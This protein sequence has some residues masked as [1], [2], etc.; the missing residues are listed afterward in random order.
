MAPGAALTRRGWTLAGAASGLIVAGRLLGAAELSVLGVITVSLL[1]AA[2]LWVR[3]RKR[4]V[5]VERSVHPHR[6]HVGGDARVDIEV[7]DPG[8]ADSPQ[9]MLTDVFDGGRRAAR[10][11]VP[12]L[13]RGQRARAAYR[14]PTNRR[15]RY[16]LGPISLTVTDPFGLARRSWPAGAADEVTICPRVHELRPPPGAPGRL[17]SASPFAVRFHAP[18]VDGEEFLTLREYEVG[19]DLRRIH[20][21]STA[22]TGE[23]VVREDEAQW[24]PRAVVLLDTRPSAHDEAS[25]EAAVEA[26]ASV[27]ARLARSVLPVEVITTDGRTLGATGAGGRH[28][29]GG[30][31]LIMD[32][33]AVV[34]TSAP[35]RL[36]G[37]V[38]PLRAQVRRG[39]LVAVMGT[40][41]RPDLDLV[42]ALGAPNAPVVLVRTRGE[43]AGAPAAETR[44]SAG[45]I[46]VDGTA[47]RFAGAWDAAMVTRGR[48]A[49]RVSR[50]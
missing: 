32:Q 12:S 40:L 43:V 36:A 30:E 3:S 39:L 14:V 37:A 6:V 18:A 1:F 28:G 10:F 24:Q 33:L 42:N 44:S 25:F 9:L 15:G 34:E 38:R 4:A 13:R 2:W 46:V 41:S 29:L 11:L 5:R 21:R 27:V 47:G 50:R 23:L 26:A 49:D 7:D 45:V 22:R 48:A 17:R 20:W 31:A 35:E 16:T 19:D 8:P